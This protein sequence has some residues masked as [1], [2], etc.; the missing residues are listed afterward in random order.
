MLDFIKKLKNI[1]LNVEIA[2]DIN[3]QSKGLMFRKNLSEDNGMLFI[4]KYPEYL[5][6]W[7]E[8]TFIPLD[9]AF[10]K[11]NKIISIQDIKPLSKKI[12]CSPEKCSIAI[13]TN[14]GFFERNKI[15]K[16]DIVVVNEN[17]NLVI[18]KKEINNYENKIS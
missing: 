17:D 14:L 9:I 4:F 10:I 3:S 12:I 8:N 7:G 6:F 1:I 11:N 16:D 15:R 2:D 18:F 5:K 13:E